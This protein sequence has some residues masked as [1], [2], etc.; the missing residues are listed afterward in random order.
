MTCAEQDPIQLVTNRARLLVQCHAV[1]VCM[2]EPSDLKIELL[3]IYST[4]V[5]LGILN[6]TRNVSKMC[7]RRKSHILDSS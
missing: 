6:T 4:R 3:N 2:I 5:K 1:Q 7:D